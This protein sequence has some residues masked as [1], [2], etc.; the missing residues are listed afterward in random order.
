MGV[1][2]VCRLGVA[3]V[4]GCV[5]GVSAGCVGWVCRGCVGWLCG[6]RV[7]GV[8]R[9]CAGCVAGVSGVCRGRGS[10]VW[11]CAPGLRAAGWKQCAPGPA[12]P[13]P[14]LGPCPFEAPCVL[15]AGLCACLPV[16]G[17]WLRRLPRFFRLRPSPRGLPLFR[18]SRP[19][20]LLP[21]FSP[22]DSHRDASHTRAL[23]SPWDF[24]LGD[25]PGDSKTR[26][27]DARLVF[28]VRAARRFYSPSSAHATP[29]FTVALNTEPHRSTRDS[30]FNPP[31]KN[32]PPPLGD[33]AHGPEWMSGVHLGG[34]SLGLPLP[35]QCAV[36]C[37]VHFHGLPDCAAPR[38]RQQ[39]PCTPLPI[40][41]RCVSAVAHGRRRRPRV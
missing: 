1:C 21:L 15:D 6:G 7:P 14:P 16:P 36:G 2:R 5:A 26:K 34:F 25:F 33:P 28:A 12:T 24:F 20:G 30:K 10:G 18:V 8:S 4:A 39:A 37:R 27:T 11:Q 19:L 3:G 40:K 17:D 32:T 22:G 35:V 9:A 23:P 29:N 41:A 13:P 31:A 38:R